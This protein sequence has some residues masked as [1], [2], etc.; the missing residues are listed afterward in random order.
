MYPSSAG[1]CEDVRRAVRHVKKERRLLL[2][3][4][5]RRFY[6]TRLLLKQAF[7]LSNKMDFW[8]KAPASFSFESGTLRANLRLRRI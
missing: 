4:G 6:F 7:Y 8:N 5:N 2:S 3:L 1:R